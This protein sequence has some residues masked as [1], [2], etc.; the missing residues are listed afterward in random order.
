MADPIYTLPFLIALI[1]M[2][3]FKRTSTKRRLFLQIGLG[4]SSLYMLLTFVNKYHVNNVYKQA[5]ADQQID[6]LRFQTQP[7]I[8]NNILWY[9]IAETTDAY[10]MGFYSILD[11]EPT[12]KKWHKLPKNHELIEGMPKD[13]ETLAWFSDG[14]YNL[15]PMDKSDTFLFKDLRYPLMDESDPN[16]SI[17][18]FTI[19]KSNDRWEA[20]PFYVS[21]INEGARAAFWARLKGI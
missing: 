18:K 12:I 15:N 19:T 10:Y 20:A 8:L 6:Y 5:L 1:I 21:D 14:Y 9:G 2:M 11:S 13:L 17:F 3:C 16:S 4:V 7:T